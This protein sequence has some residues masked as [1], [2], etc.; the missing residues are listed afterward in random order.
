[1]NARI[2]L[3]AAGAFVLAGACAA[4]GDFRSFALGRIRLDGPGKVTVAVRPKA[5]TPWKVIGLQS[6]TLRPRK[7]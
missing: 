1:M 5:G 3:P 7:P 4:W 6:L 2:R